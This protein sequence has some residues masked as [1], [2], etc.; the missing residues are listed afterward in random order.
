MSCRVA[1]IKKIWTKITKVLS[2]RNIG[3]DEYKRNLS[4]LA[5][6]RKCRSFLNKGRCNQ[7]T[8]YGFGLENGFCLLDERVFI[9]HIIKEFLNLNIIK[10]NLIFGLYNAL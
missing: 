4:F 10:H 6:V 1:T 8:I 2:I 5:N 3:V 9:V 7:Y